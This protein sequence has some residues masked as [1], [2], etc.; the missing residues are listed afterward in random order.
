MYHLHSPYLAGWLAESTNQLCRKLA[1]VILQCILGQLKGFSH[2]HVVRKRLSGHADVIQHR[3]DSGWT[4][5][6]LFRKRVK[7]L[8]A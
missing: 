1:R 2:I 7:E 6:L 3:P 8:D 4:T 5:E